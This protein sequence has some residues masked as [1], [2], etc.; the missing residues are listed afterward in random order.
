MK[1]A[2]RL[3]GSFVSVS[4]LTSVVGVVAIAQSQKIAESLAIAEAENVAQV[5]AISI[6]HHSDDQK[7]ISVERSEPIQNYIMLLHKLQQR[8]N[9]V[10]NRQKVIIAD[11]VTEDIGTTLEHDRGN[12]VQ[13]T[14]QDGKARTFLEKSNNYPQG[15]KLIVVPWKTNQNQIIGAVILEWSSLFDEAIAQAKPTM[16][17]IGITSLSCVILALMLGLQI[18]S[19]IAKPLQSVTEVA[20][21][22]TEESNFDLKVPVMAKDE[23]GILAAALNH[24]IER[25]KI[26]LTEKEQRSE[27]LQQAFTQLHNTQLQLVQTEKMSSL[28]QLVAGIAHEIN[29]PVNFIRG[30]IDHIDRYTQ[31]LLQLIQAYQEH[32][33]YP[34]ATLQDILDDIEIDFLREDLL[35][36]LQS[37]KIGTERIRQIVLSLRNFSRLDEA[38]FKSVDLHEGLENTL[39][40]LQHRLQAQPETPAIV[41]IKD[42]GELPLVE[43]YPGQL[44]QVFMNLLTNAIDALE[45]SRQHTQP[46]KIWIS[47]QVTANNCVQISIADNGLGINEILRSRIFDPFFTTKPIGK[48][49]GLGLSISY[50]IITEKHHGKIW[51]DFTGGEGTKFVIEIPVHQPQLI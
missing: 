1:I 17:L 14:I 37:M 41:V 30:N 27:E 13:Q 12:E 46:G 10:V 34:P 48:G 25:V 19:S 49:T 29:N 44:N 4:L 21:Q 31:D 26:L 33:P 51:C 6:S 11:A 16:L 42:Y 8:D 7:S 36:L 18:A 5:I 40:I 20:Q 35:K 23:T 50:K 9:E 28:G 3:V 22:V 15:I 43:C 47:T 45:D 24:L 32:Y 2:H 39:L 38:E